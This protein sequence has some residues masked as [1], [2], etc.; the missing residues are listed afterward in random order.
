MSWLNR[1]VSLYS[2]LADN[3]GTSATLREILFT[4][5]SVDHDYFFKHYESGKWISGT[6]N[7]LETIIDLRTRAHEMTK[8]ERL[9]LKQTLQCY[10]P[11]GLLQTKKKDQIVEVN[12]SG[13]MQLD[14]DY[15]AIKDYD[16]QE[17][18]RAVF[19]L[20]PFVAFCGLSCGGNGFFALVEIQEPD[21]LK[22]YAEHCFEIFNK[23][24]I[25]P[26]TTK[27]RNVN[28]LRFLSYD[29]NML[30]RDNP[31]PLKI[32]RF[33]APKISAK[34]I[35]HPKSFDAKAPIKW[36]VQS[37]QS[38]QVGNRFETVRKVAY[39]LGG[40]GYG[41]EEIKQAIKE[42]S[43]FAGVESKYLTHADEGFE[44]GRKKPIA[45]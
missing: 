12:R 30:I 43:Q 28:D 20:L 5:F 32:K 29:A 38:A 8:D 3:V 11:A 26:D 34:V 40:Y 45:C 33:N 9:M 10:T 19:D 14:F 6:I 25:P 21:R 31:K 35:T 44:A 15:E 16:I 2:C 22:E 36:A 42:C 23:Y 18:K 17:L 24:S 37:I 4:K 39:T 7:D 13:L 1:K 41:L 27:G